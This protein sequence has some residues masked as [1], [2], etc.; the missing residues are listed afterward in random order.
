MDELIR[1][2]LHDA[3]DVE[4]PPPYLRSRIINSLP[5]AERP[6]RWRVPSFQW[7]RP[8]VAALLALAVVGGLVYVGR[9]IGPQLVHKAPQ[10]PITPAILIS[11]TGVAIA[12]DGS[13]YFS[14]VLSAY[15]FHQ[16]PDGSIATVAGTRPDASISEGDKG[17]GGPA[18]SA[19]L[20]G[21]IGLAFDRSGNLY[22]ADTYA[23]R[24]RRIDRNGVITTIAGTGIADP[25]LGGYAGDGGPAKSALFSFPFGIAFDGQGALYISDGDNGQI[26]RV[27]A[28]GRISSL[29]LST[30]PM[31][32]SQFLPGFLA[33]DPAGSLYAESGDTYLA[34]TGRGC[35]IVRRTV[36]GV[37]SPVAGTGACGFSGDGGPATSAEISS[38]GGIA[39]DSAGNLYLADTY[40]HRIRR[41]DR[42]GVITTVA[43]SGTEG[44]AGDGGPSS[45][46]ELQ[47]PRGLAMARGDLLYVAEDA[48]ASGTPTAPG[49][50]R[51]LHIASGT[52][53]TVIDS[54]TPI[55]KSG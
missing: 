3:L 18:T 8:W 23:Q 55:H 54:Q 48:D 29:D 7:A 43:G 44:F 6:V 33:F 50:I 27:D 5:A 40:N 26:R 25:A 14:D 39:F 37:W 46:A 41:V 35:E 53:S 12:P 42:N 13:V 52:I 51:L 20:F 19:N 28:G 16:L 1:S 2:R 22:I 11:P 17:M 34:P 9:A 15:V 38:G 24:I 30:L 47:F 32:R 4:P 49:R 36:G 21:P 31:P 10:R 45:K